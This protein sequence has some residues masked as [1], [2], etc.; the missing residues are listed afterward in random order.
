MKGN[1]TMG[2]AIKEYIKDYCVIDFETTGL[3]AKSC[4]IIELAALKVRSGEVVDKYEQLVNPLRPI[5]PSATKVNHITDEMVSSEPI[6]DDVIDDFL[7]FIGDDII[8]GYNISSFDLKIIGDSVQS[9]R[10]TIFDNDYM[11]LYHL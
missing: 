6:L 8:L 1:I 3:N 2:K 4:S 7:N 9:L 10:H 11:D 5:P